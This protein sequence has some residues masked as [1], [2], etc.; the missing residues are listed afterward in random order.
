MAGTEYYNSSGAPSTGSSGSSSTMRAEFDLVEAGFDKMPALS[1]NGSKLVRV[2]SGGTALEAFTAAYTTDGDTLSTGF[3]FPN[4]GLHVLDTDSSHD[5]I[6]KPGSN[7][8]ADRTLT[9]TTGDADRTISISGNFTIAAAF[10]MSGAYAFTGTLSNTTTVTFPT[11]GTLATLDGSETFT[12]KTLTSPTLTTP[13][14]GEPA[15]GTLT[16]CTGLPVSGITASTSTALGVGSIEL[17]HASDTTIA[18]SGAGAIT[19]EGVAVP[20]I[21]S[22]NTLTNKR[23]QKRIYSV[24]S[25]TTPTLNVDNY[26]E[27]HVNGEYILYRF[28]DDGTGRAITWNAAFRATTTALPTTTTAGK[29]L[30]VLFKYHSGDAKWDCMAS[31]EEA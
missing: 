17:G 9:I 4:T 3:T 30:Y 10:T 21:S 2:N 20:T 8:T 6:L 22:T 19:V 26:D 23:V 29:T 16:N 31:T 15:S 14:L 12:N 13:A 18:R 27:F 28:N 25:D 1:G 5:L 7:I 24:A 11:T